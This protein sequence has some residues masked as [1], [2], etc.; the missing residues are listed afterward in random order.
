MAGFGINDIAVTAE[1][2]ALTVEGKKP[3]GNT[4]EYLYQ[5]I[6]A[7]PFRRV[8]KLADYVQVKQASFEDGLL[9]IDLVREVPES[10]KP[11]RIPI[12]GAGNDSR[13]TENTQ[14]A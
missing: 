4:R 5:G 2:N 6:A 7:L 11:R 10:M 9:V 14:A 13:K 3:D 8:F 1:Q 12:V